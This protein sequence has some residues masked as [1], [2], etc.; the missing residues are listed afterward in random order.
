MKVLKFGG[1]S[2]GSIIGIQNI[3]RIAEAGRGPVIVVVSAL[4]TVTDN[5]IEATRLASEGNANYKR[6][7]KEIVAAHHDL[8][9]AV[10]G[11]EK[12]ASS[13]TSHRARAMP[14]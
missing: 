12:Q 2:V 9:D 14:Y 7:V 1:T 13:K 4:K 11:S 3:K 6:L 5:L 10:I 8:I